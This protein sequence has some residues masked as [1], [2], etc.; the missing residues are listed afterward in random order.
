M[1]QGS[2]PFFGQGSNYATPRLRPIHSPI[3]VNNPLA[4]YVSAHFLVP[5]H[6]CFASISRDD[7]LAPRHPVRTMFSLHFLLIS[8]FIIKHKTSFQSLSPSRHLRAVRISSF[9]PRPAEG[10][11][12]G[13]RGACEPPQGGPDNSFVRVAQRQDVPEL[14]RT[15]PE[16]YR[17]HC[18]AS[19]CGAAGATSSSGHLANVVDALSAP[20]DLVCV[21]TSK[22]GCVAN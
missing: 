16:S 12:P 2:V 3:P 22:G 10:E 21:L 19:C 9:P 13:V 11:G 15:Y 1:G 7:P 8:K 6:F 18:A 14:R 17:V 20:A 4:R 5:I